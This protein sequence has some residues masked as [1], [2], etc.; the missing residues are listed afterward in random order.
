MKQALYRI[1]FLSFAAL[2]LA[3]ASPSDKTSIAV[4]PIKAVREEDKATAAVLTSLMINELAKSSKLIVLEEAMLKKVMETQG[5]NNSDACDDTS[6]QV[7]VGKLVKAQKMITGDLVKLGSR[8]ILSLKLIDIQSGTM[9]F[10]TRDECSCTED[11]VDQLVASAALK[12]REH[13]GETGLTAQAPPAPTGQIKEVLPS[14]PAT[15]QAPTGLAASGDALA[16]NLLQIISE[17]ARPMSRVPVSAQPA[18]PEK[19]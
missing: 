11:Q 8:Y 9:E 17:V 15:P 4:Y 5:L 13:F 10:S 7:E 3:P 19:R 14:L 6:C 2:L 12:I 16:N 18:A 1:I